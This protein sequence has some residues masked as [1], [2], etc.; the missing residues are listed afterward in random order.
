MANESVTNK[1]GWEEGRRSEVEAEKRKGP[2]RWVM[3]G[4]REGEMSEGWGRRR[5]EG[6]EVA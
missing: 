2:G 6:W 4:W 3:G 1:E 5:E